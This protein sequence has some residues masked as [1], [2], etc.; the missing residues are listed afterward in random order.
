[1]YFDQ[2]AAAPQCPSGLGRPRAGSAAKAR[3]LMAGHASLNEY[4]SFHLAANPSWK[5]VSTL[6]SSGKGYMHSLHYLLPLL[7][8][9][10][11]HH[12]TAMIDRFYFL[13]RDWF[14]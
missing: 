3:A 5:P 9:G 7:R 1:L 11:R 4:G 6:D 12:D 8:V 13:A 2:R 10:V 14:H